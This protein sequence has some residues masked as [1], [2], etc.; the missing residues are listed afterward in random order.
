MPHRALCAV[1]PSEKVMFAIV[2]AI[3]LLV[4][5]LALK[6]RDDGGTDL[7]QTKNQTFRTDVSMDRTGRSWAM[8]GTRKVALTP[9]RPKKSSI[10]DLGVMARRNRSADGLYLDPGASD[11]YDPS[12]KNAR[13][14]HESISPPMAGAGFYKVLFEPDHEPKVGANSYS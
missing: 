9:N 7:F 2:V 3:V 8:P 10:M 12:Q 14:A 1:A 6:Q 5:I 13:P 11:F 4:I